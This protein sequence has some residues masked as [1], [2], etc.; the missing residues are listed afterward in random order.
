LVEG[1]VTF[2]DFCS[3]EKQLW[4]SNEIV[5]TLDLEPVPNFPFKTYIVRYIQRVCV[6][7]RKKEQK[8]MFM[9]HQMNCWTSF[10]HNWRVLT[11]QKKMQEKK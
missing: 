5:S 7:K 9:L 8:N 4:G 10:K 2:S 6:Y 11:K 3:S 1:S